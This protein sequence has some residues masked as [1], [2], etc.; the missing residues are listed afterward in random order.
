MA[1]K[2]PTDA[3]TMTPV[4]GIEDVPCVSA[5]A[6]PVPMAIVALEPATVLDDSPSAAPGKV[7]ED[8]APGEGDGPL[9]I[10]NVADRPMAESGDLV[11]PGFMISPID[12]VC[13]G[14]SMIL[15]R[16]VVPGIDSACATRSVGEDRVKEDGS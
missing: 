15:G 5:S 12:V 14:A 6:R 7:L 11:A 10:N 13:C 2:P 3:P 9:S 1:A 16:E 8:S 4:G